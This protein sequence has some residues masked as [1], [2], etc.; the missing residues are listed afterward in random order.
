M[1]DLRPVF[2][3]RPVFKARPLLAHSHYELRRT[4]ASIARAVK[5]SKS[6]SEL[7]KYR[8]FAQCCR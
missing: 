2:E 5:T 3:A 7:L 6:A 8:R 4:D 1:S